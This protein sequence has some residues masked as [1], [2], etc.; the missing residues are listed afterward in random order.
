MKKDTEVKLYMQVRRTG[1]SQRRAAA[2]AGMSERT[3]R[4]YERAGK[5]PSQLKQPRTW[6]T[7]ANPFEEDW[8]W[9]VDQL[10][11]DPALQG[12]TL[13][14]LVCARHPGRYRPTQM[15]TL[16]RQIATW[17]T[18]HGPEREVIFEQQHAPGERAQ[19]DFTH[20]KDM[21]ITIAGEPFPHLL[22]HCVLTYSNTE[23]VSI[24]FSETFEALA[25][26]VEHALWQFG[27]V[28]TQHRTDHLSAAV[29]QLRAED[30][31]A[32]TQRYQALMA[33]YGMQPTWNNTGVAHEN[34][35]VEQSHH[36]FKQAVDQALR[37][38]G[39]RDFPDRAAYERFLAELVRQRNHTRKARWSVEQQALKP[40]P[41]ILLSPCR[42]L[43][44]PVSRFSTIAVLGNRYSVPSRLIGTTILVRVRAETLEGYVGTARAF[45][46]PR[47]V[48]Q[49]QTRIDYRH[50]IWSLV[51]KPGA[52]AAYRYREELFPT[53]TFRQTYDRL[54][55]LLPRRA[56]REYVRLLHLAATTSESEVD[57]ALALLLEART[58]P[59]VEAVGDVLG[60]SR[61]AVTPAIPA[62]RLDLT[63]YDVLLPS[64]RVHA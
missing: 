38:R 41:M 5:L 26:G 55:S 14:A 39:S 61:K 48:G 54:R 11:R 37:V 30:Q 60:L 20:M 24:C 16:Q 47:L 29:R 50:V 52:F 32:W 21:A 42:E 40:L 4:K 7:R 34:G 3:A 9:V 12:T 31:E 62:P 25:E 35:D 13:F 46:L 8:P 33:H 28:P 64:R 18:L 49:H 22:F 59:T 63:V 58:P 45:T 57:T 1:L 56:D 44:V 17:R 2:K 10:E 36:R 6:R 53:T 19:S 15:R 51:R 23:A 43:R 27:G